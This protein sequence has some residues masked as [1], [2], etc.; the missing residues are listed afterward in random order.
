MSDGSAA[1]VA[2]AG[3]SG[4][5]ALSAVLLHLLVSDGCTVNDSLLL[6]AAV[7]FLLAFVRLA[8]KCA[9]NGKCWLLPKPCAA[10]ACSERQQGMGEVGEGTAGVGSFSEQAD[11]PTCC[12]CAA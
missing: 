10:E 1:G 12:V 4:G 5:G 8:G 9:S 7:L 3:S 2:A 6:Q 11:A